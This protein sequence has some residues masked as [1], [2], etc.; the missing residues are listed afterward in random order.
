MAQW[1]K[2]LTAAAYV[3][4]EVQ[5]LSVARHRRL[6]DVLWYKYNYHWF[7]RLISYKLAFVIDSRI[8]SLEITMPSFQFNNSFFPLWTNYFSC[9]NTQSPL[10]YLPLLTCHVLFPKYTLH[11]LCAHRLITCFAPYPICFG[12]H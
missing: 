3:S 4:A 12:V 7:P 6:K 9:P 8:L 5:V 10:S 2:D 1:V 11:H